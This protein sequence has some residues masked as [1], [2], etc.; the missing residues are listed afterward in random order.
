MTAVAEGALA[1]LAQRLEGTRLPPLS[2]Y[3]ARCLQRRVA[4]RMRACRVE[5]VGEY[6]AVLDRDPAEVER[7]LDALTIG[8][9]SGFR[10]PEA[11]SRLEGELGTLF[12]TAARP[13]TAW[14]AGCAT[15]EEAWTVALLLADALMRRGSRPDPSALRVDATDVDPAAIAR[16]Q[17]GRYSAAAFEQAPKGIIES[18]FER[19]GGERQASDPL[20][21]VVRFQVRDLGR[22]PAPATG[23]DL[24]ACR[25]VLIYF[26]R[27]V[28]VRLV[29]HFADALRPGGLLLLGKV[30]SVLEPARRR[31]EVVDGRER[32]FRKVA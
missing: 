22:D 28:Q 25:N 21:A 3:K 18:W 15:G 27:P 32:L 31:F 13:F 16:A 4:V 1:L 20:R 10:N 29:D 7:L 26:E 6:L 9:T 30:E 17:A 2:M 11:W 24:I 14:S 19:I 8:V 23:Y 5:S 12:E